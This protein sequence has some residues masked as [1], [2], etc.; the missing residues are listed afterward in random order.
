MAGLIKEIAGPFAGIVLSLL[1]QVDIKIDRAGEFV[2]FTKGKKT[3]RISF[4]QIEA[5]IADAKRGT[6]GQ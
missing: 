6:D 4:D 2:T 1:R 3:R 5:E